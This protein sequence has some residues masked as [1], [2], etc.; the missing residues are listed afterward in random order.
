[1]KKDYENCYVSKKKKNFFFFVSP[2]V[3]RTNLTP[4]VVQVIAS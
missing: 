2:L 1:M 3:I 4:R